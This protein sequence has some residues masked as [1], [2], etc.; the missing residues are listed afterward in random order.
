M[1]L[2]ICRTCCESATTQHPCSYYMD[3]DGIKVWVHPRCPETDRIAAA[4][5]K[6]LG[7]VTWGT[8]AT[9][10]YDANSSS[11]IRWIRA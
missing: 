3:D 2:K 11:G 4:I 1:E 8:T 6:P 7:S 5:P 10:T 9:F